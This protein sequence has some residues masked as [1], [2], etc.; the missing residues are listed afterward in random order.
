MTAY[1]MITGS[2]DMPKSAARAVVPAAMS[3]PTSPRLSIL[4]PKAGLDALTAREPNAR[5]ETDMRA[6]VAAGEHL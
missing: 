5:I 3:S 2:G 6:R 4:A 1:D